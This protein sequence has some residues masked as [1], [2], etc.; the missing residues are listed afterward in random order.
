VSKLLGSA[1]SEDELVSEVVKVF[2]CSEEE[3]RTDVR[4]FL[5]ILKNLNLLDEVTE[6]SP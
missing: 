2:Q 4:A 5:I 6:A 3:A 1:W